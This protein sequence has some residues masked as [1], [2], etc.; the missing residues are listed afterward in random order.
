MAEILRAVEEDTK[1]RFQVLRASSGPRVGA[2]QGHSSG[3]G[4]NFV[5]GGTQL[6]A[7]DANLLYNP[8]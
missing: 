5:P 7:G 1:D 8:L 4:I 6:R 3:S 2:V